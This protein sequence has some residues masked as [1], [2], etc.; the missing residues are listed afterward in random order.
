[1]PHLHIRD[2]EINWREQP[3][4]GCAWQ[5]AGRRGS[6]AGVVSGGT[7]VGWMLLLT[8][9]LDRGAPVHTQAAL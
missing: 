9:L 7:V 1:M 3:S 8:L 2:P 6:A 4:L 5:G